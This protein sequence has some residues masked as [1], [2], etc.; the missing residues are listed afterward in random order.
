MIEVVDIAR[1]VQLSDYEVV[2]GLGPTLTEVGNEARQA[3]KRLRARRVWLLSGDDARGVLVENIPALV[4]LLR[5]CGLD[6]RWVKIMHSVPQAALH[7]RLKRLLL[8]DST[9]AA[10]FDDSEVR[11]YS[12]A[13]ERTAQE[14]APLIDRRDL[15]IAHGLGCAAS[16]AAL[17]RR[18]GMTALWRNQSGLDDR[19]PTTRAAW[20]FLKEHLTPYDRG[21]F[22]CAEYI[23]Q[24]FTNRASLLPPSI[25]PLADRNRTL[26]LH[27]VVGTLA[28][29]GLVESDQPSL[30]RAFA[31]PVRRLNQR[32]EL[33]TAGEFGLLHRPVVTQISRWDRLNGMLPLLEGFAR[34][35]RG[36][37]QI[38]GADLDG[39]QRRR[40]Q[41]VRLVMAGP[42]PDGFDDDTELNRDWN[43]VVE[44]Y[45]ALPA[46]IAADVAVLALPMASPVEHGLIINALQRV[47][48]LVVQ[49]SLSEAFG[50]G[51]AEA[52]YKGVPVL[53]TMASGIR[54][55]I[56]HEIDGLLCD[57]PDDPEAVAHSLNTLLGDEEARPR[58]A[59]SA[60]HR[61]LSEFLITGELR[62]LLRL[63]T[64]LA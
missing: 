21:L 19:T 6:A 5:A 25:D 38:D 18:C 55:Q 26:S 30:A 63:L 41:I 42:A 9:L 48:T 35:K 54:L 62:R 40:V 11:G 58:Y 1:S 8:G 50:L 45:C 53:G 29:A 46:E 33:R 14:L 31:E 32:G 16:G 12:E 43:A 39:R 20:S 23:P 52:A 3:K 60:Q 61:V 7:R 49:N 34:L 47:S 37:V 57:A 51:V 44:A 24:Y 27:Q 13:G 22:T 59:Q 2:P 64:E 28:S 15:V 4:A 10:S 17:K 56:R 36:Q